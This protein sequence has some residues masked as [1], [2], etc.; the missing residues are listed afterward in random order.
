MA[1]KAS[2]I[3]LAGSNISSTGEVDADLLDNIDS[4][5]FLSLDSNGRLGI[6]TPSPSTPLHVY[7]AT[8]NGVATFESGDAQGG[9]ALKDNSTT[10]PVF[11]LADG[12]DFK[13]QTNASERMR[14]NSSGNVGIGTSS[15]LTALHI[16]NLGVG[17]ANFNKGII[18][19]TGDGSFTSGHGPMLEFRNEDVYM[20]GI[21]GI[22]ESSWAS[23]LQFFTHN[24]SSGNV[25]GTTFLE[26]MRI[27][28]SGNVG[29]GTAS[30]GEKLHV[31]GSIRA[32]GNIGVTQTDGD[33][34]AKLYQSSADGFL[35][36]YTG[37]STPVS[38]TKISSYGNSYINPAAGGNVGIGTTS[39][40]HKLDVDG[41]SIRVQD[42]GQY[43]YFGSNSSVKVGTASSN[44]NDLYLGSADDINMESN[45]IRLYRDGYYGS[46]E[47]GRLAFAA[48][49][50]L[51]TGSSSHYL[52]IGTNNPTEKL[53]VSGNVLATAYYGDGYNLT[54]VG[55]STTAGAVGTYGAF[56]NVTNNNLLGP[57]S[58][59]SGSSLLWCGFFAYSGVGY[60]AAT[61]S[62]T[63]RCMGASGYYQ[64]SNY[65]SQADKRSTIWLR[66]S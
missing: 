5:A 30:P 36:L 26:R 23:G 46:T 6:G 7:N 1:T 15:P 47:Y 55:G 50:W 8:A 27:D 10:Q 57:G 37:E 19:K 43:I 20:A 34:L 25:Y 13:V 21:T 63:W 53:H 45:F 22:R 54:G 24:S 51:C 42:V 4:A 12:N 38:R 59:V 14:I 31:E 9:I 49:S 17:S 64:G 39:P 2:R 60:Q 32:S 61:P 35:E 18:I 40:G 11:L 62:G 41:G 58:T 33:Y 52:G 29:I 66:I 3:A 44:S 65:S 28:A 16:E 48:D 56:Y